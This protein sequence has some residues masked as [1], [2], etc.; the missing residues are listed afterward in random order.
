MKVTSHA[1]VRRG[2]DLDILLTIQ[3]G[4]EWLGISPRTLLAN[5]RRKKI[6]AVKLNERTFRIHPRS[7]L[8]SKGAKL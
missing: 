2:P 3:Q 8:L 7:V 5:I 4:A 6:P 1:E